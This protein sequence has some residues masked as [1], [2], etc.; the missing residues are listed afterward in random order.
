[1][2]VAAIMV[3]ALLAAMPASARAQTT[4]RA[5]STL[6]VVP[7]LVQTP[8]KELVFALTADD[9]VLT[10]NGVVQKLT[11]EEQA[12]RPLALVVLM[13]TGGAARGQFSSYM[14]L[15]KMLAGI[16]GGAPSQ[17]AIVSFDSKPE[18][19]TPFTS[20]VTEWSD[21]IDQ[22]DVGDNGVAIFDSV[23]YAIDLLK[24]QPSNMRRA[25]LLISQGHDD[26]S[27]ASLKEVIQSIG[28]TNTAIYSLTFSAEK[29]AVR[30]AFKDPP[31][32]N[33]PLDGHG[34]AYF[35]LSA[36]LSL[37]IGAMRRNLS[38]AVANLSGG[39]ANSFD[40]RNDLER[41]LNTLNNHLRNSY[42]LSFYPASPTP[43]LHTIKV[44]LAHH[45]ELLVS[46]RSN[47]WVDDAA[48]SDKPR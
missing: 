5:T 44:T 39:E 48:A 24:K 46:A 28:E 47:Y 33:P 13:Q 27:K 26:S 40:N 8:D 20:D 45:P 21:A 18:G 32:L 17:A 3:G 23:L 11:L 31:H 4:L 16:L 10:D 37:A 7:T 1:M 43:G 36:P 30:Q 22:P 6:V 19:A 2:K 29:T 12:N 14:E 25:I 42:I 38:A 15:D 9:F 41:D 34:Q 35:N